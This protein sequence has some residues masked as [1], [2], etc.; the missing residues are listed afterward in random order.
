MTL[1]RM[2]PSLRRTLPDPLVADLWPEATTTSV[3]DVVVA[4]IS[5]VRL[6]EVYGTPCGFAGAAVIPHTGGRP[7]ASRETSVRVIRIT[8]IAKRPGGELV[9]ETDGELD[10]AS[11][12]LAE[13][14]LI[15]RASTAHVATALLP[16]RPGATLRAELPQDLRVGDLLAV[17]MH[18]VETTWSQRLHQ[19]TGPGRIGDGLGDAVGVGEFANQPAWLSALE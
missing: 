4:G 12:V 15:G 11:V 17:P 2:I 1:T 5:L 16:V 13:L 9:V 19:H 6:A 14:R 3:T 7:S 8:Q 18:P 10:P